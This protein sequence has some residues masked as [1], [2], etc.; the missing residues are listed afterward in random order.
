M[1]ALYVDAPSGRF[2]SD[3]KRPATRAC[4]AVPRPSG[5]ALRLS[6]CDRLSFGHRGWA[7]LPILVWQVTG[8]CRLSSHRYGGSELCSPLRP[9]Q[10]SLFVGR[11][12]HLRCIRC[13]QRAICS[14]LTLMLRLFS[15]GSKQGCCLKLQQAKILASVSPCA[16]F[17]PNRA[18]PRSLGPSGAG[19]GARATASVRAAGR[20]P[21]GSAPALAR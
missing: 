16:T 18:G 9:A 17:S 20:G 21:G 2:G 7:Y 14:T 3:E 8:L 10:S 13:V 11:A 15:A 19:Q 5:L 12:L 4:T 6:D 1:S